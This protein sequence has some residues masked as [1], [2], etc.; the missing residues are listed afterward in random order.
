MMIILAKTF[1]LNTPEF[2]HKCN[3][4]ITSKRRVDYTMS[5]THKLQR[6]LD[7]LLTTAELAEH[8]QVTTMTIFNWRRYHNLP[9]ITLRSDAKP[10]VRYDLQDVKRWARDVK[11]V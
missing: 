10:S 1:M 11:M 7:N 6:Q 4:K 3:F 8:F 5:K 9:C 2:L